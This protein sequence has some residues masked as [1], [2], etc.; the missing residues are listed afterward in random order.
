[1]LAKLLPERHN[2]YGNSLDFKLNICKK[3]CND[4]YCV[5]AVVILVISLMVFSFQNDQHGVDELPMII[6]MLLSLL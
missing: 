6:I 1:M 5:V 4:Y 3:K 2:L